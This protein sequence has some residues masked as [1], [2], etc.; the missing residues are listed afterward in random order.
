MGFFS[1]LFESKEDREFR[2]MSESVIGI[3]DIQKNYKVNYKGS[4]YRVS[5]VSVYEW[6]NGA[7]DH[8]FTIENGRETYY[9]NYCSADGRVSIYWK[10]SINAVWAQ[11]TQ[12]MRNDDIMR[13]SF[14]HDGSTFTPLDSGFAKVRGSS[15]SY[16]MENWL[17]EANDGERLISFNQ[18]EDGEAEAYKGKWMNINEIQNIYKS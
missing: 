3:K 6:E 11:A 7:K 5:D 14:E 17:F 10:A 12:H 8:E 18:Y 13:H 9:L 15:E 16:E 1:R 4:E 2:R